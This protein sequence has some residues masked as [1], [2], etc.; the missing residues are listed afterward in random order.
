MDER[1]VD[2]NN[3]MSDIRLLLGDSREI[4]KGLA[5][6]SLDVCICDPPYE[7]T[8]ITKR[9]GK[10]GA[11]PAQ[12]GTNGAFARASAGLGRLALR[13]LIRRLCRPVAQGTERNE[14]VEVVGSQ[15]RR[16]QAIRPNVVALQGLTEVPD[17]IR[18]SSEA[19]LAGPFVSPL[20]LAFL[21]RPIRASAFLCPPVDVLGMVH[22]VPVTIATGATAI[23]SFAFLGS[24]GVERE[25]LITV[26]TAETHGS[27][28]AAL[29]CRVLAFGR[30]MKPAPPFHSA[31]GLL[32]LLAAMFA[33]ALDA[34]LGR[35]KCARLPF[36]AR[37]HAI[38][39][40]VP[41]RIRPT[42]RN[43]KSRAADFAF[44][45]N[46]MCIIPENMG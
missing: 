22:T 41:S 44:Q 3:K 7:L 33:F 17:A 24:A 36:I 40:A 39:G 19:M 46:H 34:V 1:D 20:R 8:S 23:L 38:F 16:E 4:L 42:W 13:P 14:V 18:V 11:A 21:C 37:S 10:E 25:R 31:G 6:N 2:E 28:G 35:E 12:E 15:V 30:T 5:E 27:M 29:N 32:K 45:G 43:I 9:F 26:E